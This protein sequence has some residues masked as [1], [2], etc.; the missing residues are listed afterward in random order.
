MFNWLNRFKFWKWRRKEKSIKLSESEVE[1]P[2][3]LKKEPKVKLY[4]AR[5]IL[6]LTSESNAKIVP[7]KVSKDH[8]IKFGKQTVTIKPETPA[9]TFTLPMH[10]LWPT[11]LGR[12]LG[13]RFQRFNLYACREN[14]E[15]THSI[16]DDKMTDEDRMKIE[17]MLKLM[18]KFAEANAG[19]VLYE[20]IKG[21]KAWW[22]YLPYI[23]IMLIV[24]FF[25]FAF[26]VQPNL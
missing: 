14:G 25:L 4:P 8:R 22:D 19:A 10:Q 11:F 26:Q 5:N 13:P 9:I 1:P 12:R 7:C 3:K 2:K 18:G 24:A 21:P 15:M 6:L 16:H 23:M 17:E 20:G